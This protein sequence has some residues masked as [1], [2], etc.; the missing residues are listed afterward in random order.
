[1]ANGNGGTLGYVLKALFG[2][3]PKDWVRIALLA[4]GLTLLYGEARDIKQKVDRI[5]STLPLKADT[6]TLDRVIR[7][8]DTRFNR[9]YG[10]QG[11]PYQGLDE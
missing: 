3:M 6:A 9:L 7:K 8:S 4:I 11:W 5:E 1:M 2:D 10:A